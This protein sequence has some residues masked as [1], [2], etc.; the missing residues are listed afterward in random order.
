[1]QDLLDTIHSL[2]YKAY[3]EEINK[4]DID[5]L[6]KEIYSLSDINV[7]ANLGHNLICVKA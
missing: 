7:K 3:D 6:G 2:G 5:N 4:F 1:M